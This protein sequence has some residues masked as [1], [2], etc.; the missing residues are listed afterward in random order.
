VISF[1]VW[2]IDLERKAREDEKSKVCEREMK[3]RV[4]PE[5]VGAYL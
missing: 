3:K 2:K 5:E 4:W 1:F